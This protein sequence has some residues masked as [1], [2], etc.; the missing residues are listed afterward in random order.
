MFNEFLIVFHFPRY[1]Y[2]ISLC[3]KCYVIICI[4]R[5]NSASTWCD[6]QND[7]ECEMWARRFSFISYNLDSNQLHALLLQYRWCS[8]PCSSLWLIVA[9]FATAL[10]M[11][12]FFQASKER[13]IRIL[14]WDKW[15]S[16]CC[17]DTPYNHLRTNMQGW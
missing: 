5:N 1:R 4:A 3:S 17:S 8:P 16:G 9:W 2:A 12:G 15:N 6:Y 14:M 11:N 10:R 7:S 13:G